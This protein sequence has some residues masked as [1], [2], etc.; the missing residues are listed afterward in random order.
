M[1]ASPMRVAAVASLQQLKHQD[2][3]SRRHPSLNDLHGLPNAS[4]LNDQVVKPA[5]CS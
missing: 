1:P 4:A 5:L 3:K 2:C